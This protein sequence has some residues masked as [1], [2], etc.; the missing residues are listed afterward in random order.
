MC[1]SARGTDVKKT[2]RSLRFLSFK[3]EELLAKLSWGVPVRNG[4]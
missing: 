4:S 3:L 2:T 1:R